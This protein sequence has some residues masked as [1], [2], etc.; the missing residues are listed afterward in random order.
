MKYTLS[1]YSKNNKRKQIRYSWYDTEL[2]LKIGGAIAEVIYFCTF[3]RSKFWQLEKS[4][5]NG[6][7]KKYEKDEP[8]SPTIDGR[9]GFLIE[10]QSTNFLKKSK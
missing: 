10:S 2:G 5:Y 1:W 4:P 8:R 3:K 7:L 6:V 9:K